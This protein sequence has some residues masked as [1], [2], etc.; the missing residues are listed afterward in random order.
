LRI[1]NQLVGYFPET[2][3]IIKCDN[4]ST[5]FRLDDS[6]ITE[7]GVRVRCSRCSHTF[8][9]RKESPGDDDFDNLLAGFASSPAGD[10]LPEKSGSPDE[11]EDDSE[12]AAHDHFPEPPAPSEP[13]PGFSRE[14]ISL[15]QFEVSETP[16]EKGEG[17]ASDA[18]GP[19]A[20]PLEPDP[21]AGKPASPELSH[22]F[23]QK[24]VALPQFRESDAPA[25]K[26]G[27]DAFPVSEPGVSVQETETPAETPAANEAFAGFFQKGVALPQF[28]ESQGVADIGGEPDEE[29]GMAHGI[30]AS[31]G[32]GEAAGPGLLEADSG[33]ESRE[34]TAEKDSFKA[35]EWGILADAKAAPKDAPETEINDQR[36]MAAEDHDLPPLS[37]ASRRR[38]SPLPVLLL[39]GVLVLLAGLAASAFFCKWPVD[40]AAVIPPSVMKMISSACKAGNCAEI[41]SLNGEFL[42]NREAGEIFAVTGEALNTSGRAL[43]ALRVRG[44]VYDATG[45]VLAQRT[46]YCGNSLT[47]D[48]MAGMPFSELEK[49]MNRQFGDSL[50]NLDVAPGKSIPFMVVFKG[51]PRGGTNFGAVVVDGQGAVQKKP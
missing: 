34:V 35:D 6:R 18:P 24:G 48:Q 12:P 41:S 4:C 22:G 49:A 28:R 2:I 17:I 43:T 50:A 19:P 39:G 3:M 42:V 7:Q 30:A 51:V 31:V 1:S 26:T 27:E 23:F 15:P 36:E 29:I 10:E 25:E 16:S 20:S 33:G 40:P 45:Q 46:V 44:T 14:G 32:P 21:A 8:I 9:V 5:K 38:G 13:F 11:H 37:I 47:R